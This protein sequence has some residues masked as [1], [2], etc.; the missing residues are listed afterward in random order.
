VFVIDS[1]ARRTATAHIEHILGTLG[2]TSG[3][4]IAARAS[5]AE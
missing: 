3:V 5:S 2:F 1:P 4:Q